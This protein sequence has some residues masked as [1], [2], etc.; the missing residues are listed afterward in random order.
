MNRLDR[1]KV[2]RIAVRLPNW[3][4]DAVMATPALQTL[5]QVYPNASLTILVREN[6]SELFVSCSFVEEVIPLPKVSGVSKASEVFGIASNL[7]RKKLDLALCFPHSFSSALIFWLAGIPHRAGFSAEDRKMF[8]TLSLPYPLD[9]E[10]PHRVG[11]YGQLVELI[12]GQKLAV[13]PLKVWP[14]ELEK[15][16]KAALEKKIG[17]FQNLVTVAPGS[18]GP[19]KRWFAE[20][21]AE[22]VKKLIREKKARV[23]LV[24]APNDRPSSEEVAC[25]S[26]ISPVNLAGETS[27]SEV[28][29]LFQKSQL[30][31]GNDS[32]AGHL[33][34]AAGIPVVILAGAGDPDEISPW[35]DEKTVLFKK[36]FCSPCYRNVCRRKDHPLECL[37]LIEVEAVWQAV[38]SWLKKSERPVDAV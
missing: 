2:N 28:Y 38:G 32:G 18:V 34:A 15:E 16:A 20:R 11:F 9:G 31:L 27:L 35:T 7:R 17:G 30:F 3:L 37:D 19:A 10:R 13:P 23:V 25:L 26:G 29:F 21:Y 36:I 8:L 6:L 5:H 14:R 4:G 33:A 12:A 22:I 24:G 1:G